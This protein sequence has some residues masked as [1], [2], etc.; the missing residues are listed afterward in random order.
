M[1]NLKL[2][3][4]KY[5]EEIIAE[6][7]DDGSNTLSIK[8]SAALIPAEN[9]GWHLVTWLPYT[10][11]KD[12]LDISKTEIFFMTDLSQDMVEYYTKWKELLKQNKVKE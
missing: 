11:V 1:N 9:N 3:K 12:G 7:F 5:G 8:N 2:I 6:C 10:N 4:F